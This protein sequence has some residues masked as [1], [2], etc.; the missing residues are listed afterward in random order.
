MVPD[1]ILLL[2]REHEMILDHLRMIETT[3]MPRPVRS[4]TAGEPDLGT[5]R[6]LFH[7]F[8]E[9]VGVHFKREAVLVTAL[10]GAFGRRQ[11]DRDRFKNL[12][13]EHRTLKVDAAGIA[14]TLGRTTG[15]PDLLRIQSFIER[16]RAH[17]S[18]EKRILFVLAGRRLTAEQ[19]LKVSRRM[20]QA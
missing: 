2:Q 12:L 6:E 5:L 8:T 3:I 14:K 16:F 20:L 1:P 9:R 7:F 13:C 15:N 18:C 17:L 4:R 11:K 10:N 19:R